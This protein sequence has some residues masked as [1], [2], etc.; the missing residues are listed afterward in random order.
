MGLAKTIPG[1]IFSVDTRNIDSSQ[2]RKNANIQ[3]HLSGG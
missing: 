3:Q 1:S 2:T